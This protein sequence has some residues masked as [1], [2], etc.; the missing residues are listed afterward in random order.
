MKLSSYKEKIK[1]GSFTFPFAFYD[2]TKRHRRYEMMPHWHS[3]YEI[4]KIL[5]GELH[6][7]LNGTEYHLEEGEM[8]LIQDGIIHSA[9]PYDCHYQCFLFDIRVL[10]KDDSI[11]N[12]GIYQIINFEKHIQ[13]IYTDQD[14]E[15]SKSASNLFKFMNDKK[16]GYH[17][18]V[19][20]E[21]YYFFGVIFEKEYFSDINL[22]S[23]SEQKKLKQLKQVLAYMEKNY[24][25]D[26]SLDHLANSAN[27]NKQYFCKFFKDTTNMTPFEFLNNLRIESACDKI[28]LSNMNMTEIAFECGFNDLSYFIKVFKKFKHLTPNQYAKE[29]RNN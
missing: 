19:L 21:L 18:K 2:V 10:L 16:Q 20:G 17:F 12:E 29:L 1:H 5:K 25:T 4:I 6:L 26:V 11:V 28:A 9:V 3:E 22:I 24:S 23:N 14:K 8:A 13:I 27:M 15:L 7:N